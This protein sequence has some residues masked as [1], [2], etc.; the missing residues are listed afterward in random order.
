MM[1]IVYVNLPTVEHVQK[2]VE[3]I[4]PLDGN[5]DLLSG[6]YVLDAKSLMSVLSLDLSTPLILSVEKDTEAAMNAISSFITEAPARDTEPAS[7]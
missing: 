1:R 4:S 3:Q 6:G 5:F 7:R 2:F